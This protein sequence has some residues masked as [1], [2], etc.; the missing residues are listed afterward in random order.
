MLKTHIPLLIISFG[1]TTSKPCPTNIP[2]GVLG[3]VP[4]PSFSAGKL[5]YSSYDTEQLSILKFIGT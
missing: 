1:L 4:I 3:K 2:I 5:T